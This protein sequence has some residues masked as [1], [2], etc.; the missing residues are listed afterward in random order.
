MRTIDV[1]ALVGMA[2]LSAFAA[3]SATLGEDP[4]RE[5][6]VAQVTVKWMSAEPVDA[7]RRWLRIPD[8]L[9]GA[10][11]FTALD[12]KRPKDL[13]LGLTDFTVES[14]GMIVLAASWTVDGNRSGNWYESRSTEKSLIDEGW[15]P[16]GATNRVT[17]DH[18]NDDY[19]LF[20]RELKAGESFRF[21]SR[22][23]GPP[24]VILPTNEHLAKIA[25]LKPVTPSTHDITKIPVTDSTKRG[26][27]NPRVFQLLRREMTSTDREAMLGLLNRELVRQ[28][29]LLS[30]REELQ[31]STRDEFLGQTIEQEAD[32]VHLPWD[33]LVTAQR[34]HR[35]SMTIVRGEGNRWLPL[36]DAE[37]PLP[38]TDLLCHL[39]TKSEELS[40]TKF[41]ELLRQAG[42]SGERVP[43]ADEGTVPPG[44]QAQLQQWSDVAQFA[45]VR[46]LHRM[47]RTEGESAARLSAVACG[48]AQ[49]GSL[50]ELY[51]SSAHKAYT[52]RA[53]LYAERLV[54]TYPELP[55]SYETRSYVRTLA[56]LHKMALE[57]VDE[58]RV[59]RAAAGETLPASEWLP[60]VEAICRYQPDVL[61]R[62]ESG[63]WL[64]QLSLYLQMLRDEASPNAVVRIA[65]AERLI[66]VAPE[67]QRALEVVGAQENS[68]G[69]R[70]VGAQGLRYAS[71]SLYPALQAIPDLPEETAKLVQTWAAGN[72]DQLS[73]EL[74]AR[75]AI[76]RQ[77]RSANPAAED[78]LPLALLGNLLREQNYLHAIRYV[79]FGRTSG[80][81]NPNSL[82]DSE[83]LQTTLKQLVAGHPFELYLDMFGYSRNRQVVT[84]KLAAA[85]QE[86]DVPYIV[87][88]ILS[89]LYYSD[90]KYQPLWNTVR[91][92]A[93][94]GF[95]VTYRELSIPFSKGFHGSMIDPLEDLKQVS[96][97]QPL[98]IART[99]EHQWKVA[100]SRAE[101][102]EGSYLTSP[103]VQGA[104]AVAYMRVGQTDAAIRCFD[105]QLELAPDK[106]S[107]VKLA[108]LYQQQR[109]FEQFE[110][111]LEQFL[112]LDL[113]QVER[114][115]VQ[116]QL[117]E[118][119]LTTQQPEKALPHL[120]AAAEARSPQ[121][122]HRLAECYARLGRFEEGEAAARTLATTFGGDSLLEWM[123][124]CARWGRGNREAAT[125]VAMRYILSFPA[126]PTSLQYSH[127]GLYFTISGEPEKAYDAIQKTVAT[128]KEDSKTAFTVLA[129]LMANQLQKPEER[130]RL[131]QQSIR[132][133]VTLDAQ[134]P[135]INPAAQLAELIV[136]DLAM[137]E[138]QLETTAIDEIARAAQHQSGMPTRLYHLAG[139]YLQ[140]IGRPEDAKRYLNLSATSP[141]IGFQW[142]IYSSLT[143]Q[144]LGVARGLHR[145]TELEQAAE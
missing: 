22:K 89:S 99:I 4:A 51:W 19:V 18:R 79:R 28:A 14:D 81:A 97:H 137:P 3:T 43:N 116:F 20:R 60:V 98:T 133:G 67:C 88:P 115:D 49:L 74:E 10:T 76:I 37:F 5:P 41:V 142:A 145:T 48:Y 85:V 117:G 104:L 130:D 15:I 83:K 62:V 77:L 114:V 13:N 128:S 23:Y 138:S 141:R 100:H 106:A 54:A 90:P 73:A 26:T 70:L 8:Y 136:A 82:E 63:S 46:Q 92:K 17:I 126:Q 24:F 78:D 30:A 139:M 135:K 118:H 7:E 11:A 68:E 113:P 125:Q 33:V 1:F 140:Q 25:S 36:Y 121:A 75:A 55:L 110:T 65:A 21:H 31:L 66:E 120:Q 2:F 12:P 143:L 44:I 132:Y 34:G 87:E 123:C 71:E 103:D 16:I 101:E 61:A 45:A 86:P 105:R 95:D 84:E 131:L 80:S 72:R 107:F 109:K 50:T 69:R 96:P 127:A 129:A 124:W 102:W 108:E 39:A 112:A 119:Y 94:R 122:Y 40:R 35:V 144:E 93:A 56:G 29:I 47:I 111:T 52:A 53:M 59:R 6:K 134:G 38:A 9:E 32:A 57:D 42:Y 58:A 64:E 27:K 91:S